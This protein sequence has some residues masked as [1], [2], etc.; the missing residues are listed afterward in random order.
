MNAAPQ[1]AVHFVHRFDT[2]GLEDG[3]VS[4]IKPL[5]ATRFGTPSWPW[6]RWCRR[7]LAASRAPTSSS[8]R[9]TRPAQTA[10]R[11]PRHFRLFRTL[12]PAVVQKSNLSVFEKV[13]FVP[14]RSGGGVSAPDVVEIYRYRSFV[15]VEDVE[16]VIPLP[17]MGWEIRFKP[18]TAR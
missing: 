5:P 17:H 7:S 15:H 9:C 18:A 13:K 8:S 16:I 11:Y 4:L 12:R 14:V 3:V 2:G 6:T 1:L 10:R